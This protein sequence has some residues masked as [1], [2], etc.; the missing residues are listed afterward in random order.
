M[1]GVEPPADFSRATLE[2]E[3][4][5]AGTTFSR[6]LGAA[7]PNPLG[8]GKSPSRF[9]D[10]RRRVPSRRFGVLYLGETIKVCFLEA[11]LRDQRDGLIED[12]LISEAETTSRRYAEIE[13]ASELKLVDLRDDRAIRMGIPSDVARA[14]RQTLAR[15]WSVAIYDHPERPDGIIY[16]SRL[17]GATNIALYDRAIAKLSPVRVLPLIAAPGLAAVLND[18]RIAL[19]A[20]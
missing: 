10:P 17:S 8:F 2:I 11:V 7:Y 19:I 12:Y 18:L 15:K 20:P 13:V 3:A 1:P 14:S 16:P 5:A 9:S 4:T 6:I